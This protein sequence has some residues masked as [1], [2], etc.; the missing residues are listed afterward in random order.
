MASDKITYK[1]IVDSKGAVKSLKQVDK[2]F[3]DVDRSAR[4]SSEGVSSFEVG[5]GKAA[6]AA[7]AAYLSFQ[8]LSAAVRGIGDLLADGLGIQQVTSSFE[9]LQ[10]AAGQD[11]T[12]ALEDLQEATRGVLSNMELMTAANKAIT[13]GLPA[14]QFDELSAAA[15]RLGSSVGRGP[16]ESIED[17]VTGVGRL[18]P[19]ILDN[20]GIQFSLTKAY[21]DWEKQTGKNIESL[22]ELEKKQ[23]AQQAAI[24]QITIAAEGAAEVQ[25][26]AALAYKELGASIKNARDELAGYLAQSPEVEQAL[27]DMIDLIK[28][29]DLRLVADLIGD[30]AKGVS[31]L[32]EALKTSY[33]WALK[34]GAALKVIV[35]PLGFLA[36]KTEELGREAGKAFREMGSKGAAGDAYQATLDLMGILDK[37]RVAYEGVKEVATD[38]AG[39]QEKLVDLL[40]DREIT[41]TLSTLDKQVADFDR[42]VAGLLQSLTTNRSE[43]SVFSGISEGLSDALSS[44]LDFAGGEILTTLGGALQGTPGTDIGRYGSE[45]GGI[46]GSSL[47]GSLATATTQAITGVAAGSAAVG[48]IATAVSTAIPFLAPIAFAAVG[49]GLGDAIADAFS[50][51]KNEMNNARKAMQ[52]WFA[53]SFDI[54]LALD[55]S[56]QSFETGTF[57]DFFQDLDAEARRAFLGAGI[58]ITELSGTTEEVGAQMAAVFANTVGGSINDLQLLLQKTGF[59]AEQMTRAVIDAA[60]KG[61]SSF[62]EA[63]DAVLGLQKTLEE[64]IPDGIGL[65]GTAFDNMREAGVFGGVETVEALR[66]M[67]AEAKEIGQTT[68]ADLATHLVNVAG[69]SDEAVTKLVESLTQYGITSTEQLK[70][71][72]DQTA[73]AVLASL[74][75]AEFPFEETRARLEEVVGLMREIPDEKDVVI[76]VRSNFDSNTR[77]AIDQG[78]FG[79][80]LEQ[81]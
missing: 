32:I 74:E 30:V 40:T 49:G 57:D 71:I 16:V 10:V 51:S 39:A 13:L 76:N 6:I 42:T 18:S 43:D 23:V 61:A 35:N 17:L 11:A 56:G 34:A 26:T 7:G 22:T 19:L 70:N 9:R 72:S 4:E 69:K 36:D 65:V 45:I 2:G 31:L 53:D 41:D 50:G 37:S 77:Q 79:P 48:S 55:R 3:E 62:A 12:K 27:N 29:I 5:I 63:H 52:E 58:A 59:S 75:N 8:S 33:D 38:T 78:V 46:L 20:L 28:E 15:I 21:E 68:I 44:S 54:S 73:V 67:G 66:D 47:S 14:D 25:D 1:L 80:G 60:L 64:G 24:Q 81:Q